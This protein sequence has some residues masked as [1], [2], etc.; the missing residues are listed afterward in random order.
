[1]NV[2]DSKPLLHHRNPFHLQ[3]QLL[4]YP[5]ERCW[6]PSIAVQVRVE[7][8]VD[9]HYSLDCSLGSG[10]CISTITRSCRAEMNLGLFQSKE[11]RV[12][13]A[14]PTVAWSHWSVYQVCGGFLNWFG[15]FHWVDSWLWFW[16]CYSWIWKFF[17]F[18]LK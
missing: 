8:V 10:D 17:N 6:L 9:C 4:L 12:R 1:M 13:V 14:C 5:M 15:W 7:L 16:N 2:W 3:Y 11:D 18:Y